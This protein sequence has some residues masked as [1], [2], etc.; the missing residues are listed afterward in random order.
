MKPIRHL[1]LLLLICPSLWAA[2]RTVP[3][4]SRE[5][6]RETAREFLLREASSLQGG[7]VQVETS[8]IDRR[9]RLRRCDRPLEAFLPRGGRLIGATSVGVRCGGSTPW[10]LYVR[11]QV[12]AWGEVAVARRPLKRGERIRAEDLTLV[13][14]D[15]SRLP[16][17]VFR[18]PA[19][20]VDLMVRRDIPAGAVLDLT[21][22]EKARLVRRGEQVTLVAR[23]GGIEVR[24]QGTALRDAARDETVQ[25]RNT[26]SKRIVEGRVVD[27]G[28]VEVGR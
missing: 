2:D 3:L 25:V 10:T 21:Q 11:A 5:E 12:R 23:A 18:D 6:I 9:L 26:R 7:E 8:P 20:A 22:L 13:R 14:K 17:S 1:T 19:S 15:L 24:M 4:Q 27:F 16:D 28:L